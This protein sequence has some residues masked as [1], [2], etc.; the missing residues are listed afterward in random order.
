MG[1]L[2]GWW[3]KNYLIPTAD[4]NRFMIFVQTLRYWLEYEKKYKPNGSFMQTAIEFSDAFD[5]YK[6]N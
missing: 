6:T 4:F 2:N 5:K 1:K 3:N